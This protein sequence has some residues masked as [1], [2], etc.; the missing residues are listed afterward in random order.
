MVNQATIIMLLIFFLMQLVVYFLCLL[1]VVQI[2]K[3]TGQAALK[4]K[5]LA[6]DETLF[7]LGLYVGL[8]CTVLSLILLALG[9]EEASLIA[10]YASTLFGVLFVALLKVLHLRPFRRQLII[11]A[12]GASSDE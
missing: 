3:Q 4:L 2:K 12:D 5:L 7:D 1:R 8:G 11:E 10:A 6:N 9:V